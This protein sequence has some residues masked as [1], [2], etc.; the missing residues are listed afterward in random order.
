MFGCTD[1]AQVSK[2]VDEAKNAYPNAF[3]RIIRFDNKRLVQYASVSLLISLLASKFNPA[4][5]WFPTFAL[6][7]WS[8][9]IN[10]CFKTGV[11][12]WNWFFETVLIKK[13]YDVASFDLSNQIF[14][15]NIAAF[16]IFFFFLKKKK[17]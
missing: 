9:Q 14:W 13:F 7:C 6:I 12:M 4:F 11:Y 2:E 17:C 10:L 8:S 15:P 1:P 5:S 3:I 16:I